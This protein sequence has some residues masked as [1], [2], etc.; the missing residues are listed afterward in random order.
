MPSP[1]DTPAEMVVL[2]LAKNFSPKNL[3]MI[4]PIISP[5]TCVTCT[6]IG[7]P[8]P[9]ATLT[10]ENGRRIIRVMEINAPKIRKE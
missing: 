7:E 4:L 2:Y 6:G 9:T 5:I 3:A 1:I 8:K 10:M